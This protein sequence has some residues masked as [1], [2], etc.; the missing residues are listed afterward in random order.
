M[1]TTIEGQS[2]SHR[3]L[4]ALEKVLV[5]HLYNNKN[6]VLILQGLDVLLT[7]NS[8]EEVM[9]LLREMKQSVRI[10]RAV[11]YI[12]YISNLLDE[13]HRVPIWELLDAPINAE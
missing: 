5:D 7:E 8:F 10:R 6:P 9:D 4:K 12:I 3:D 1:P 2:I 13:E 11:A